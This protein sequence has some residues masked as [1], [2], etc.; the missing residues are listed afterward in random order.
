MYLSP[1]SVDVTFLLQAE[2]AE[3]RNAGEKHLGSVAASPPS[4]LNAKRR[5]EKNKN[6]ETSFQAIFFVFS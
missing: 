4:P 2:V 3:M 1:G 5:F 6:A